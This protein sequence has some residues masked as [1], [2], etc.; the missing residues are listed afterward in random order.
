MQSL[1]QVHPMDLGKL[2]VVLVEEQRMGPARLEYRALSIS[3][4]QRQGR[5]LEPAVV[6]QR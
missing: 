5:G 2:S 1:N 4:G 3:I 6:E